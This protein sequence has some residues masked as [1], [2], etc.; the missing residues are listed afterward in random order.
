MNNSWTGSGADGLWSNS[1]NWSAG[2]IPQ[3]ADGQIP[4]ISGTASA[5]VT[6]IYDRPDDT[7][8]SNG[9]VLQPYAT[10][11]VHAVSPDGSTV[12]TT[13]GVSVAKNAVLQIATSDPVDLGTGSTTVNGVLEVIGNHSVTMA[14]SPVG[15]GQLILDNSSIAGSN[16]YGSLNITLTGGSTLH[17]NGA[18]AGASLTFGDPGANGA[19][20]RL[21]LPDWVGNFSEPVYNFSDSSVIEISGK[22]PQSAVFTKNDDGTYT[23]KISYDEWNSTTLTDIH[24][25]SGYSP[26]TAEILPVGDDWAVS[27]PSSSSCFLAGVLIATPDGPVAVEKLGPGDSVVVMENGQ[28]EIRRI[29]WSGRAQASVRADLPDDE[30][31]WPVRVLRDA[32]AEGVP[33]RDLLITSGHCLFM[34]G[35]FLPVRMLVNGVSVFYDRSFSSYEY[36]HIETERHSVVMANGVPTETYLDTGNTNH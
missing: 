31:G 24:L 1:G 15:T 19:A 22:Q 11:Q 18:T 10:L 5:P 33:S 20:N 3:Q 16:D 4:V 9:L 26:G 34:E 30:A 13:N 21:V 8:L 36:Y 2:V 28:E 12:L 25:W 32:F 7:R 6:V 23:L 17:A 29:V 27:V 35:R 14:Y